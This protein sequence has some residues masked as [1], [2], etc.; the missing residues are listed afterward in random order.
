MEK[1]V[2]SDRPL[3]EVADYLSTYNRY[4]VRTEGRENGR[5]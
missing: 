4:F 2:A 5:T 1:I 3:P